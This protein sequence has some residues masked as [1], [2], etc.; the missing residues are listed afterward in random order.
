MQIGGRP[1]AELV[2][3]S[4]P[5]H[6]KIARTREY[7]KLDKLPESTLGGILAEATG[8]ADFGNSPTVKVMGSSV[9][10]QSDDEKKNMPTMGR[11]Y[12]DTVE[13]QRFLHIHD[14]INTHTFTRRSSQPG[15]PR[16]LTETKK[17][18]ADHISLDAD[19]SVKSNHHRF[20]REIWR[21]RN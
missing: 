6:S 12:L 10:G 5:R 15:G 3:P 2:E 8:D 9:A 4:G 13:D 19:L 11:V 20:H 7:P 17:T 16:G 14:H 21:Q 1:D 18:P